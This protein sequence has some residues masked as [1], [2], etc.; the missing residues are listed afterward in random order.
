MCSRGNDHFQ[1]N[2]HFQ[3][4]WWPFEKG[5]PQ[6]HSTIGLLVNEG[7]TASVFPMLILNPIF[8]WGPTGSLLHYLRNQRFLNAGTSRILGSLF[9]DLRN[10]RFQNVRKNIQKFF[11]E[12]KKMTTDDL[13]TC[14][15]RHR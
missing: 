9:H 1:R 14:R 4:M 13:K 7:L 2:D 8:W 11:A 6:A 10:Q 12:R 15:L 3:N 5:G